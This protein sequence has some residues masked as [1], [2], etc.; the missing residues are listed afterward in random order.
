[1]LT[2]TL[3][4]EYAKKIIGNYPDFIRYIDSPNR[5]MQL[6]AIRQKPDT[7]RHID[8]PCQAARRMAKSRGIVLNDVY[9]RVNDNTKKSCQRILGD[10]NA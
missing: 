8:N 1:M 6:L 4:K 5:D 3:D 10:I 9:Y 7:I 2:L